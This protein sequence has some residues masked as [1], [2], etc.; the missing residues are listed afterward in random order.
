MEVVLQWLDELDDA[1]F[2]FAL[3]WERWRRRNVQIGG[4]SAAALAACSM[5]PALEWIPLLGGI[6]GASAAAVLFGGALAWLADVR[7]AA[8]RESQSTRNA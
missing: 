5:S 8:P 2:T 4:V 6:A 3:V 7:S 1:I